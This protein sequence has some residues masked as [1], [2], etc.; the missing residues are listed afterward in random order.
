MTTST[1][2]HASRTA[3]QRAAPSVPVRRFARAYLRRGH[4]VLDFGC[5]YGADVRWLNARGCPTVGHDTGARFGT[6]TRRAPAG[7][8]DAVLMVY[9]VNVLP[10]SRRR[11]AVSQAWRHVRPGGLMLVAAR[12]RADVAAA[13]AKG[14]W[15]HTRFGYWVRGGQ[16]Q[17]G[18]DSQDLTALCKSL[19]G[20]RCRRMAGAGFSAIVIRK[21]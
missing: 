19:P 5:G 3:L 8:Y 15:R 14:D 21:A 17:A 9:V 4:R 16:Y 2:L 7:Q 1:R 13:A 11:A 12:P 20:A 6:R 18:H 10:E